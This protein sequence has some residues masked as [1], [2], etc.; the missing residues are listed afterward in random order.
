[1]LITELRSIFPAKRARAGICRFD[2]TGDGSAV[3]SINVA[4][5]FRGV[6][7]G[8]KILQE[9]LILFRARFPT[10]GLVRAK[11]KPSNGPSRRVFA[12]LAFE[13]K[14][15]VRGIEHWEKKLS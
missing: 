11:I 7:L 10:V 6:G 1:M 2:L 3:V 12:S 5:S 13:P 14:G 9:A 8:Q 4:P 15:S